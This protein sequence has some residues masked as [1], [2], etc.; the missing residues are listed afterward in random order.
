IFIT[1]PDVP[2]K[3]YEENSSRNVFESTG[4][5]FTIFSSWNYLT[6]TEEFQLVGEDAW[7]SNMYQFSSTM[8]FIV[9]SVL[10]GLGDKYGRLKVIRICSVLYLFAFL[11][12]GL[13]PIYSL[14]ILGRSLMGI[15]LPIMS[16]SAYTLSIETIPNRYR[17]WLGFLG[18]LT[19]YLFFMLIGVSAYFIR[20]WRILHLTTGASVYI[21]PFFTLWLDES[22]RWLIQ[23]QHYEEACKVLKKIY[24]NKDS[25]NEYLLNHILKNKGNS[26]DKSSGDN[27]NCISA[28]MIQAKQCI[29]DIFGSRAMC[30]LSLGLPL[31]WFLMSIVCY[32][33]PL[34]A[35]NFTDNTYLYMVIIGAAQIPSVLI[36]PLVVHRLGNIRSVNLYFILIG[37]SLLWMVSV[38]DSFWWLKWILI[39]I[40]MNMSATMNC[41]F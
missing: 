32:G 39:A 16:T 11:L 9:G 36:G 13:S 25:S 3:S 23:R 7:L 41:L 20:R 12:V 21:L 18:S 1:T 37:V 40:S 10:M 31:L 35:N 38:S 19:Y 8:G 5:N 17:A 14:I 27:K 2:L 6:F 15:T 26:I 34:N 29:H 22:P 33:I 30:K 28:V 4:S 24:I